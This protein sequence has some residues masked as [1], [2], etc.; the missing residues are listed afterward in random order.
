MATKKRSSKSKKRRSQKKSMPA[1]SVVLIVVFVLV[2]IAAVVA[3]AF[4]F[5]NGYKQN[6]KISVEYGGKVYSSS[7]KGLRIMPGEEIRIS[8]KY[9]EEL[10]ISILADGSKTEF[11]FY[12]GEEPWKWSQMDGKDFT[13]AFNIEETEKGIILHCES[14]SDVISTMQ[15]VPISIVDTTDIEKDL[16]KLVIH[17]EKSGTLTL[18]F[19][20]FTDLDLDIDVDV[21]PEHGIF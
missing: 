17:G 14:L 7:A 19:T 12:I 18:G 1:W 9:D 15:G 13:K 16:F 5:A 6:S 11:K 8:S 3:L 2:I 10:A 4:Y 21:L 20:C